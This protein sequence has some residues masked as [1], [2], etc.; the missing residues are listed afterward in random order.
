LTRLEV[1]LTGKYVEVGALPEIDALEG[2]MGVCAQ[3]TNM[4]IIVNRCLQNKPYAGR[5]LLPG[6]YYRELRERFLPS[7]YRLVG[8]V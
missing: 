8:L 7:T 3:D 1:N 4:T 2:T 6:F 5:F